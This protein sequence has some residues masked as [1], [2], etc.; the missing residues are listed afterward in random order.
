MLRQRPE[1]QK[2]VDGGILIDILYDRQELILGHIFR[3]MH[4]LTGNAQ[5]LTAFRSPSFIRHVARII[6]DPDHA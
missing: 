6:P 5:G 4:L 3:Q 2:A 1:Q